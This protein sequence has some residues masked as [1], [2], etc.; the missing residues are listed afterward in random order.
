MVLLAKMQFSARA[1][2][3]KLFLRSACCALRASLL[4][5]VCV[6]ACSLVASVSCVLLLRFA[7]SVALLRCAHAFSVCCVCLRELRAWRCFLWACRL[8]SSVA[9]RELDFQRAPVSFAQKLRGSLGIS[10]C[11]SISRLLPGQPPSL[12]MLQ[13]RFRGCILRCGGLYSTTPCRQ[14]NSEQENR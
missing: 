7:C 6:G 4:R 11:E 2:F 13:V 3:L 10:S 5:R 12:L 9:L 14:N 8:A 1:E